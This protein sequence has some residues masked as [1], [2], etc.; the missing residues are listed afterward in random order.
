MKHKKISIKVLMIQRLLF[1][2]TYFISSFMFWD[3][4]YKHQSLVNFSIKEGVILFI[5][6]CLYQ[7]SL[8]LGIESMYKEIDPINDLFSSKYKVVGLIQIGVLIINGLIVQTGNLS[9]LKYSICAAIH[10]VCLGMICIIH[11]NIMATYNYLS[12]EYIEEKIRQYRLESTIEIIKEVY[13]FFIYLVAICIV[14]GFFLDSILKIL[15]LLIANSIISYKI[16]YPCFFRLQMKNKL[17]IAIAISDFGIVVVYILNYFKDRFWI[18]NGR[19]PDEMAM[20]IIIFY[21][22]FYKEMIPIYMKNRRCKY[23]WEK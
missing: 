10:I 5:L 6:L 8:M 17:K 19:R 22:G 2:I 3:I 1:S 21:F 12:D 23:D 16:M 14:G 9:N 20:L 13:I 11:Y 7:V 4:V 15:V 18:F